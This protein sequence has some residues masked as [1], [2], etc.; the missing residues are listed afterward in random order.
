M[1]IFLMLVLVIKAYHA[2]I[3]FLA[4]DQASCLA[5]MVVAEVS[6]FLSPSLN[7]VL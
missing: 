4:L 6:N 5:H 7:D 2:N 1:F 3:C